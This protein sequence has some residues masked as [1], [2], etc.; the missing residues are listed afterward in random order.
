M[1]RTRPTAPD[2]ASGDHSRGAIAGV[3]VVSG[4]GCLRAHGVRAIGYRAPALAS[5]VHLGLP[6]PWLTLVLAV[7]APLRSAFAVD[8][9]VDSPEVDVLFGG[10]GLRPAYIAQSVPQTG[11]QVSIHPLRARALLGVPAAELPALADGAGFGFGP[12][13]VD[14]LR[15]AR[16][17]RGRFDALGDTLRPSERCTGLRPE[18]IEAWRW[19]ARRRG[20]GAI[21]ELASHV[22]L[23]ARQLSTLFVREV[24]LP[25]KQIARLMR[26]DAV[27][28]A[29]GRRISA[30]CPLS[31]ADLAHAYGYAD[32][33]HLIRDFQS[34]AG[35]APAAWATAEEE[36]L[37]SGARGRLAA[38]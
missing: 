2:P 1:P 38:E 11:V 31:W 21:S 26:H 35:T 28:G 33:S 6:G 29:A 34:L 13:L 23:S 9:L 16:D 10:L 14:R 5:G 22:Q 32:Q 15:T 8:E 25:P 27:A 36:S 3:S 12:K 37:R 4:T 18:L 20:G 24:G 17:W 7:E 30:G 19:L